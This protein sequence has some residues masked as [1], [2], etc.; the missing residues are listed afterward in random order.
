LFSPNRT[1]KNWQEFSDH[2]IKLS[3]YQRALEQDVRLRQL[4]RSIIENITMNPLH[5]QAQI[6]Q[7]RPSL[8]GIREKLATRARISQQRQRTFIQAT[9]EA[10][11]L[12]KRS[13]QEPR[14]KQRDAL[15][16]QL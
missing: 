16:Q 11:K 10:A 14:K 13:K 3:T 15:K 4:C 7:L 1:P 2:F 8:E 12:G 6:H 5:V 9:N